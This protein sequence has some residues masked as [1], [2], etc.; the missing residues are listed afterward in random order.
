MTDGPLIL[1]RSGRPAAGRLTGELVHGVAGP[2]RVP[3]MRRSSGGS[4]ARAGARPARERRPTEPI[5]ERKPAI[6]GVRPSARAQ[7]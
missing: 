4:A 5:A 6:V 2:D 1:A 3:T 7:A